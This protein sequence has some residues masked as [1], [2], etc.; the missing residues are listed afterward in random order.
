LGRPR[1]EGTEPGKPPEPVEITTA[2][3]S[4]TSPY[5]PEDWRE[6]FAAAVK[7]SL[8]DLRVPEGKT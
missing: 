1:K 8:P 3:N 2:T 5:P 6:Q 7:R 4:T